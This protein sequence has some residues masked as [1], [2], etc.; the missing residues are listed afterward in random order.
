MHA[1]WEQHGWNGSSRVVRVE[2]RYKRECLRELDI[3]C[4]YE[5][6]DQLAGLWANSTLQWLR[7]TVP[8][9]DTNRGR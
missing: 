8:S 9:D 7:H 4:P 1:I 2:F 3:E 6:L 5:L